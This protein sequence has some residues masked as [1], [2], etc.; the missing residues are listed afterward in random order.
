M[1]AKIIAYGRTRDEALARLRRAMAETT[2]VIEGGATN[3]SFILDLL[4]QSEVVD[5]EAGWADTSWIDRVRAEG[6]LVV[7]EH[8]GIAVVAA[9]IEAYEDE[10]QVEVTRLLESARGGRPQ[11][12]HKVGRAVDFKLR[13]TAYKVTVLQIGP[14]RF[15]VGVAAGR[16]RAGRGRRRRAARR[17]PHPDDRRRP[18]LPPG[19]RHARPRATWSRSTAWPTGS[20]ATRA[21]CCARRPPRWSSPRRSRSATWSRPARRCWCWRA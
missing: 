4:D 15:R 13:G 20:A 17:V 16:R 10:A 21:A 5:G 14:Q 2:V 1:I 19:H 6:R 11:V 12:Q 18:A 9:G 8:S 3:K 7:H